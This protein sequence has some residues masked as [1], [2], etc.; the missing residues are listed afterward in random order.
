MRPFEALC[1]KDL[2]SYEGVIEKPPVQYAVKAV[3]GAFGTVQP[4]PP[5]RKIIQELINEES[6]ERFFSNMS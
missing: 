5:S 1:F 6:M 3:S 2:G 4:Q